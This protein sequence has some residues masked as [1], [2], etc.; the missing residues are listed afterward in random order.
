MTARPLDGVR[1]LDLTIFLSGPLATMYLAGLGAEVVKIERPGAGD[2]ARGNPPYLGSD[3]IS[4]GRPD[5]D[6]MSLSMLKRGRGKRSL[7]IDLKQDRGRQ[8]FLDLLA[9]SDVVVENFRPGTMA[10]LGL[11]PATLLAANPRAVVC[12]ISGFGQTGPNAA[13]PAMDLVAQALSGMMSLTGRADDPP[14]R[15]GIA[16]GDVIAGLTATIAI[17]AALRH[18]DRTGEGQLL[19]ISMQ[20]ALLA[21]VFDEAPDLYTRRGIPVR[22]G[23]QRTR[24]TPFNSYRAADGWLVITCGNDGHWRSLLTAMGRA[25]LVTSGFFAA[26]EQRMAEAAEVDAFVEQWTSARSQHTVIETLREHGVP[27]APVLEVLQIVDDAHVR[28]RGVLR[29]VEHPLAGP[30]DGIAAPE[31]PMAF[32]ATPAGFDRA[33]PTLGQDTDVVLSGLLGLDT[34]T[35]AEL[36]EQG[37]VG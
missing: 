3:G 5:G 14:L 23:N 24:L 30:V 18:R 11:A 7:A 12:S 16:S 10:A 27:C 32:S 31:L 15:T 9:V 28:F 21:S 20:D 2:P 8:T 25:D 29:P 36:R 35:I 1:V 22:T 6:Q 37:V 17:L 19:D 34:G 4:F 13:L 33:A 26:Q